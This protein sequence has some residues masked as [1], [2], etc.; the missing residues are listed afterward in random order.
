MSSFE[1][2]T[3]REKNTR[4]QIHLYFG[5]EKEKCRLGKSI[6]LFSNGI[7]SHKSLIDQ[8]HAQRMTTSQITH[9]CPSLFFRWIKVIIS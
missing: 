5:E 2:K 4:R 9:S 3:E 7:E 8:M 6:L 1:I